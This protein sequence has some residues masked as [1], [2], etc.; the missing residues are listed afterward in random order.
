[1]LNVRGLAVEASRLLRFGLVG[2]IATAMYSIVTLVAIE[3]FGVSPVP[4]S[5]FG[6]AASIGISYFGHALYSF[7][8]KG[9][10]K[11]FLSRFLALAT[12]SFVMSTGLMWLLSDVMH[13][14][15]RLAIAVVAVLVPGFSYI[16]N[17]LWVFRSGLST[18]VRKPIES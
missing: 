7:R 17:R 15:H 1:M 9:N 12:T 16:C 14:P 13:V 6:V 3:A 2:I 11:T 5:A 4:A 10:H 18:S 8:V